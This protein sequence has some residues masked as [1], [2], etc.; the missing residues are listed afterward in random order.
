MNVTKA[1]L[2]EMGD[3]VYPPPREGPLELNGLQWRTKRE[4]IP[5]SNPLELRV[6]VYRDGQM[7][8]SIITL[9]TLFEDMTWEEVRPIK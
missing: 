9:V 8:E 2:E 1:Q 7:E 3:Y 5:E 4:V 6:H